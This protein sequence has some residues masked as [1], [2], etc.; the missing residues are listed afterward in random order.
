MGFCCLT[1]VGFSVLLILDLRIR[2]TE[3]IYACDF[4]IAGERFKIQEAQQAV[5]AAQKQE[6]TRK[7]FLEG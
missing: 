2:H 4:T 6:R 1:E 3:A 7:I 5:M